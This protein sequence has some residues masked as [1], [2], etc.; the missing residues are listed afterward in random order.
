MLFWKPLRGLRSR[1]RNIV[2]VVLL[3]DTGGRVVEIANITTGL[4]ILVPL[5]TSQV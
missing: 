4:S 5:P 2:L 1:S 3:L